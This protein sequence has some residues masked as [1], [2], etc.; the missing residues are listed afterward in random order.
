MSRSGLVDDRSLALATG[1]WVRNVNVAR[2]SGQSEG[3]FFTGPA[4]TRLYDDHVDAIHRY[5]TRRLGEADGVPLV[6]ETFALAVNSEGPP[7]NTSEMERSWLLAIATGLLRQHE[8]VEGQRL[9]TWS[10]DESSVDPT[11]PLLGAALPASGVTAVMRAAGQLEPD[12]R[13]LL[14]LTVWEGYPTQTVARVLGVSTGSV[15][16]ALKRVRRELKKRAGGI[17]D[18]SSS[19]DESPDRHPGG[20][21]RA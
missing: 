21:P 20:G 16:S 2:P 12:D 10:H 15:S 7:N 4:A 8:G 9:A 5:L 3:V 17:A 14:F 11:D 19:A 6:G 1:R 18:D 13:D